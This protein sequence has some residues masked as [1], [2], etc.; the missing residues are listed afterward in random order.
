M[1]R[2]VDA[3]MLTTFLNVVDSAQ[4]IEDYVLTYF[5]DSERTRAFIAAYLQRRAEYRGRQPAAK[6]LT[7]TQ[8]PKPADS[9]FQTVKQKKNKKH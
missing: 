5:S 1:D 4:E 7:A 2:R 6:P 8:A 9:G 3:E